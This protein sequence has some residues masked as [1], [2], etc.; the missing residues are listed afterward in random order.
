METLPRLISPILD[1]FYRLTRRLDPYY[2]DTFDD[3]FK[4]PLVTLTQWSIN[5]F[6][7]NQQLALG[8]EREL[9]DENQLVEA[10]TGQMKEFLKK[11]YQD[12]QQI[13]ERAGNTKTYGL[14]KASFEILPD[15]SDELQVG[16]F[17][18]PRSYPAYIRFGGPGPLA[19]PDI[20]NN[21]IL[22]IGI[23]LMGV[24]GEK[25]L[26]DEQS[27]IDFTGISCPTF[28]TPN[29]RENLKL[30][31]NTY[32]DTGIWYFINPFDSHLRDGLMQGLYARSYANPLELRYYSCVP[33]RFGNGRA[34]QY[35]IDPVAERRAKVPRR[36]ADDYLREAMVKTLAGEEVCFD[37]KVQFQTDPH[38]MPIEDASVQWPEK[39]SPFI[40]L[41]RIR[42][43]PQQFD[44]PEQLAFARK[45]SY[46][47]WHTLA[48]HQPLGNQNR[49]RRLI[50]YETAKYR[51]Q[52]N[53]EP[54]IE[55]TGEE[56]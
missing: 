15:L 41:A 31:Q 5:L 13:A 29:L 36:P 55:P 4:Q 46:N 44:S 25:L 51:Q 52:I 47:P 32:R 45:L 19:T 7:P 1:K 22:S 49:G 24:P 21:G 26:D 23:K 12:K 18:E 11:H 27:T 42:I 50:Y 6:R 16:L 35:V 43:P 30:Q 53:N 56:F 40:R 38:R 28:T 3:L 17:T 48:A 2:R 9:P 10:I 34:V 20:E 39:L 33:Y 8:E 14:V 37:F 54:H